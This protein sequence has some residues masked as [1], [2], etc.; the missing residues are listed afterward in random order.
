MPK[1]NLIVISAPSGCGKTTIARELLR[2]HPEIEF[3]VSATTRPQRPKET[4]GKDYFFLTR[5]DFQQKI[6][7]GELVEWELIYD[8]YYGTLKSEVDRALRDDK[9]MVFDVDVKG[10]LSI[11]KKYPRDAVLIFIKPPS[12]ETLKQ[13]LAKRKTESQASL[14][15]RLE[16]VP[17][18][19]AQEQYF[20]FS[21]VNDDIT[22]TVQE[23]EKIA[24]LSGDTK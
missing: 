4:D 16:R 1:A 20:D 14:Q 3:S 17:M 13:R 21:V 22:R 23:V 11:K 18:E 6:L 2:R 9:S 24:G 15:K 7:G 19:L 10:A 8:D 5:E 12:I